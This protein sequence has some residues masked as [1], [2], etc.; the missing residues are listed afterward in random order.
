MLLF[1]ENGKWLYRCVYNVSARRTVKTDK[2][3]CLFE[4]NALLQKVSQTRIY[5]D[6]TKF[7]FTVNVK[8]R[9]NLVNYKCQRCREGLGC[10]SLQQVF[11]FLF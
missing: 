9:H 11:M 2:L 3:L 4:V 10:K 6:T 1:K 8:T 5:P 7:H